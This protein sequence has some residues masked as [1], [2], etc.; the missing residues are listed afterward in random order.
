VLLLLLLKGKEGRE[1]GEGNLLWKLNQTQP[2]KIDFDVSVSIRSLR[3][4][5]MEGGGEEREREGDT[6]HTNP[7][8]LAAPQRV[9]GSSVCVCVCVRDVEMA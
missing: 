9:A 8:L 7:S 2:T 1:K 3:Q 6:R 4:K 5:K